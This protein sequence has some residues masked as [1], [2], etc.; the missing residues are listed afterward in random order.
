[1]FRKGGKSTSMNTGGRRRVATEFEDGGEMIE[2]YD[3]KTDE[4]LLRKRR[5]RTVLGKDETWE[6]LVGEAPRTFSPDM[7]ILAESSVNP[8]WQRSQDTPQSFVWRVRNLQ[9][10]IETYQVTCDH[11]DQKIVIRTTNKKFYK[12]FDVPELKVLKLSLEDDALTYDWKNNT[13]IVQYKKPRDVIKAEIEEKV[14]TQQLRLK[15]A[16]E[17]GDVDCKQQ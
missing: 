9:Y 2:E 5:G 3:L 11:G 8:A 6:Y 12:R 17:D 14:E 1:M 10:P 15:R 13:L 4:L 7:G 16:P